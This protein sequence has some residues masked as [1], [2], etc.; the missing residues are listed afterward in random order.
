[1]SFIKDFQ[2]P[3]F[4]PQNSRVDGS[5]ARGERERWENVTA[6]FGQFDL[7]EEA[8]PM[9]REAMRS[10]PSLRS[11]DQQE[12]IERCKLDVLTFDSARYD[13]P[14]GPQIEV[15]VYVPHTCRAW[16]APVL[17]IPR[18]IKALSIFTVA[19]LFCGMPRI[20]IIRQA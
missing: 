15:R 13:C 7:S 10:D 16:R 14:D 12:L 2:S 1:M 18:D 3:L 8:V 6:G 9:M 4:G 11:S 5:W 20:L 17:E 19:R